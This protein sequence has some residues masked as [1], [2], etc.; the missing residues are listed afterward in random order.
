MSCI[1]GLFLIYPQM[2]IAKNICRKFRFTKSCETDL[3]VQQHPREREGVR[4]GVREILWGQQLWFHPITDADWQSCQKLRS[5]TMLILRFIRRACQ[6]K[7]CYS[8]LWKARNVQTHQFMLAI[9]IHARKR[10]AK[11]K[12]LIV[13]ICVCYKHVQSLEKHGR[14][15]TQF[16]GYFTE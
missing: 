10:C 14:T 7:A 5:Q 6:R 15:R 11:C 8:W 3:P 4:K 13:L 12:I 2:E 1:T 16:Q 9:H